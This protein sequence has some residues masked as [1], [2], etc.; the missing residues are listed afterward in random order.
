MNRTQLSALPNS[1]D[2]RRSGLPLESDPV[3]ARG[4]SRPMDKE[5]LG[6]DE[7]KEAAQPGSDC[8]EAS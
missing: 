5:A 1:L 6:D 3:V 4:H 7:K 8:A 2:L